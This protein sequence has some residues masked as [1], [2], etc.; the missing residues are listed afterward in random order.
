MFMNIAKEMRDIFEKHSKLYVKSLFS[1]NFTEFAD[2]WFE[3][4][5]IGDQE[6]V[7][8]YNLSGKYSK[9]TFL[10]KVKLAFQGV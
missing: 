6:D 5:Q 9:N 4:K 7:A 3:L 8:A 10:K 2:F 1:Q